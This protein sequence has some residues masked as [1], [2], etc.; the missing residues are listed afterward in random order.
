MNKKQQNLVLTVGG[1]VLKAEGGERKERGNGGLNL[2]SVTCQGLEQSF[3]CCSFSK[4]K[5]KEKR[6]VKNNGKLDNLNVPNRL[7]HI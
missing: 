3:C 1:V 7:H 5:K 4:K 2:A 6:N